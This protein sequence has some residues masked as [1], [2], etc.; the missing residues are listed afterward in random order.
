MLVLSVLVICMLL[1]FII[2]AAS[3]WIYSVIKERGI[4]VMIRLLG[5]ILTA[6]AVQFMISGVL[7]VAST[8]F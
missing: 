6:E 5:I 2:L 4:R 8:Y 3:K 1:T 7:D